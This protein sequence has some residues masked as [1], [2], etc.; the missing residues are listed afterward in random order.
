MPLEPEVELAEQRALIAALG[1]E[2]RRG[3][4]V[5]RHH[6]VGEVVGTE[7]GVDVRAQRVAAG[8]EHRAAGRARRHRPRVAE[9]HARLRDL[10]DGGHARR[11]RPSVAE[12]PHL[13]D[14]H[15]VHDD[16]Q[17]VR[18]TVD[19]PRGTRGGPGESEQGQERDHE[20]F[21]EARW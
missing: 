20:T 11:R 2:L 8:E 19:A 18:R 9:A 7:R 12:A 16:E 3:Q 17:D 6:R 14:A 1:Q 5:G 21:H 13:V 15:V 4:L 10:V